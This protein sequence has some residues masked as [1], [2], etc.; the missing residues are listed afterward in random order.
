MKKRVFSK[1]D[2]V[3]YIYKKLIDGEIITKK[4][5][6][7]RCLIDEVSFRRYISTIRSYLKKTHSEDELYYN[8]KEDIYYL[9]KANHIG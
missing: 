8:R 1:I 9:K 5:I 3:L 4:D 6:M 7:E 2:T